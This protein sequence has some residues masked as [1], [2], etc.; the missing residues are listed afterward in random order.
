MTRASGRTL[1]ELDGN[2]ALAVYAEYLGQKSNALT[3]GMHLPFP[4]SCRVPDRAEPI[5]RMPIAF[6]VN[7]QSITF[8]GEIPPAA[9]LRLMRSSHDRLLGEV[10]NAAAA[11]GKPLA[12]IGSD[13]LVVAVSSIGRAEALGDDAEEES[14]SVLDGL[15]RDVQAHVTGFY[16]LAE[17]GATVTGKAELANDSFALTCFMESAT[18]AE[19]PVSD[20]RTIPAPSSHPA[21]TPSPPQV[22]RS[23]RSA[24]RAARP[25]ITR[26]VV[27]GVGTAAGAAAAK[28]TRAKRGDVNVV[29]FSGRLSES[30]KGD[31]LGRELTGVVVFDLGNVERIT[32]F[33]VREW[34]QMLAVAADRVKKIYFAHC[35]EA[36][37][38]QLSMIRKFAGSAQVVSFFAPY[39]CDSC[40]E[41]FERLFDCE[42]DAD[43]IRS[44]DAPESV[45]QRCNG[46]GR[47]DDD[48]DTYLAFAPNHVGQP[49]P[50]AVRA[51][52]QELAAAAPQPTVDAIEKTV[53]GELTRVRVHAK[54][55][56][57]V[58][59][60]R[61]LDGIEGALV[62]DL[63]GV[64]A[65][66]EAGVANFESALSSLGPEVDSVRLERC[67]QQVLEHFAAAGT[68]RRVTITSTVLTG[69]C[70]SCSVQRPAL[71]IADQHAHAIAAGREPTLNCKRCNGPLSLVDAGGVVQFLS[72]QRR[73]P[74]SAPRASTPPP[75]PVQ[76]A[77]P[78][79]ISQAPAPLMPSLAPPPP[80]ASSRGVLVGAAILSLAIL[81]SAGFFAYARSRAG[82]ANEPPTPSAKTSAAAPAWSAVADLPPP[83]VERPFVEENNM[84]LIVGRA[85]KATTAEAALAQARN[86]A[87]GRVLRHLETDLAG[88][89]VHDF[90]VARLKDDEARRRSSAVAERYLRQVGNFA[91]PDR[92]E[93]VVR[94][95]EGGVEAFARYRLSRTS[96]AQALA[97]YRATSSLQGMT[98]ARVFP[99][100]EAPPD[101]ELVVISVAK[102]RIA[103]SAGVKVGD[104]VNAGASKPVT[105]VEAFGKLSDDWNA[106]P[107]GS[108][109][110]LD[111]ATTT[112]KSVVKLRK[113]YPP[114]VL[115]PA[116]PHRDPP[117]PK[118]ARELGII[119][120]PRSF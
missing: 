94:Q 49:I 51:V 35:S 29:S 114:V 89:P 12:S 105:T 117:P 96:Y 58:R 7:A 54:L 27:S 102:G 101:S 88:T 3:P 119:P 14:A 53:E 70:P 22:A 86:E 120:P 87:I 38:N 52:L 62:V 83:W 43:A 67:P 95:R 103:D 80:Q 69:F 112:S 1:Y 107:S 36:I 106:V 50:A 55:G 20:R 72:R 98:V 18:A 16:S 41:Q 42:L 48:P 45:C 2:P 84:L 118:P 111:V 47:F 110:D 104:F 65:L 31:T 15:P 116:P 109:L 92:G 23:S 73:R 4:I 26:A 25:E 30:F 9:T 77:A 78:T 79:A 39:L 59:W 60:Q 63:G 66:D 75:A 76:V 57:A 6:D 10:R 5:V 85:E 91:Q 82:I 99:T 40:G 28:I 32:S 34:L 93:T 37:V 68:P 8:A 108:S 13:A 90:L 64:A 19:Q 71:L 21:E 33:G 81:I 17:L 46:R 44:S 100:L 115:A 11:A 97:T 24:P 61:I 74:S 113:P 56:G